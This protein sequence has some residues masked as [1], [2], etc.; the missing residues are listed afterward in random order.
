MAARKDPKPFAPKPWKAGAL[1]ELDGLQA[2]VWSDGPVAASVWAVDADGRF[3]AI[4]KPSATR[5]ARA[6]ENFDGWE[7][8]LRN[9]EGVRHGGYVTRKKLGFVGSG[10]FRTP[11]VQALLH[12]AP[13]CGKA[14]EADER[15]ELGQGARHGAA[16]ELLRE[17]RAPYGLTACECIR[18]GAQA[19]QAAA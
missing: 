17:H 13:A 7:R 6:L 10:R 19:L 16:L 5:P 3:L 1:V 11:F 15:E 12:S 9:V 14:A 2:T 18:E 4:K 8:V